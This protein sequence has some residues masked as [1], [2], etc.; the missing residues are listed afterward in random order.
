MRSVQAGDIDHD[1]VGREVVQY[2]AECLV[3]EGKEAG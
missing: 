2:V 3:A 1:I